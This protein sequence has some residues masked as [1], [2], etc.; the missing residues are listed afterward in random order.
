M[1]VLMEVPNAA[2]RKEDISKLFKQSRAIY[3]QLSNYS[4]FSRQGT[5]E[6]YA[7]N[8][9][10]G[11]K[12]F[13]VGVVV[14]FSNYILLFCLFIF[15]CVELREFSGEIWSQWQKETRSNAMWTYFGGICCNS[16]FSWNTKKW[17]PFIEDD[18]HDGVSYWEGHNLSVLIFDWN[19]A[20]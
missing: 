11:N 19:T 4:S 20:S 18:T 12:I 13:L 7:E 16:N 6:F 2:W 9:K 8:T 15:V 5:R 14:F 10:K 3:G 1:K 17:T